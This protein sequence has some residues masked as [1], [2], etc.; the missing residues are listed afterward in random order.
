MN[1]GSTSITNSN[2]TYIPSMDF[3]YFS[4]GKS[5]KQSFGNKISGSIFFLSGSYGQYFYMKKYSRYMIINDQRTLPANGYLYSTHWLQE[6]GKDNLYDVN[7]E[8][9]G[10]ISLSTPNLPVA[11]ATYDLYH[12]RSQ[13]LMESYRAYRNDV[14]A[15]HGGAT[16][17]ASMQFG[18]SKGWMMDLLFPINPH[19]KTKGFSMSVGVKGNGVWEE[20]ND[21]ANHMLF[22]EDNALQEPTQEQF[23]FKNT[24]EKTIYNEAY[25]DQYGGDDPAHVELARVYGVPHPFLPTIGNYVKAKAQ[26]SVK[27]ANS[28]YSQL[29]IPNNANVSTSK[30]KRERRNHFFKERRSQEPLIN[31]FDP[32]LVDYKLYS[33][34][35]G[36]MTVDNAYNRNSKPANHISEITVAN[37][38]G[39]KYIYGIP[40]YNN[41]T[42]QVSKNAGT[43]TVPNSNG[44]VGV[45]GVPGGYDSFERN[46]ELPGYATDYL[47]TASISTDYIDK[48]GD[49]LSEDDHGSYHK[50]N[51]SKLHDNYQWRAPYE[52][53][54]GNFNEAHKAYN[55]DNT[56]SYAYGNKEIWY[57]HSI[58]SKNYIAE[59]YLSDREDAY[60]VSSESGGIGANSKKLKKLDKIELYTKEERITKG[61]TAVPIKTVHFE[62]DYTLC[63]GIPSN[64]ATSGPNDGKLT[65]RKVYFTYGDSD[66]GKESVYD[67]T[68]ADHNHNGIENEAADVNYDYSYSAVDRWGSYKTPVAV[69]NAQDSYTKQDNRALAD[70]HAAAWRLSRINT[71][72]GAE[73]EV[74]YEADDY[75]YVQNKRAM[76]MF[77]I[78]GTSSSLVT[79]GTVPSSS[80]LYTGIAGHNFLYFKLQDSG[81]TQT[82]LAENYFE[83]MDYLYYKAL[84]RLVP[85]RPEHEYVSGYARVKNFGLMSNGTHAW[86]ELD[87]TFFN[88]ASVQPVF[89]K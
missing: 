17:S 85:G 68:Y 37:E 3:Q 43:G 84:V 13:G 64:P 39:G 50:F 71:P 65:L 56:V 27:D 66:K 20:D 47:L 9:S 61:R 8:R 57:V 18:T 4:A 53:S 14:G 79:S 62:Y 25:Y 19:V 52:Q 34:T 77:N 23:Y 41:Y 88:G 45:P 21:A 28:N 6:G 87:P 12:V 49:G 63:Q 40:V 10:L 74:Y 30:D 55:D 38:N 58:E 59:F 29:P 70:K 75:A 36:T 44:L 80:T 81:I 42:K 26:L 32:T 31:F 15:Y 7:K 1:N 82:E 24:G 54:Q 78:V 73:M 48:T 11:N 72:Q 86:L 22:Q 35:T 83:G 5:K 89:L 2:T 60:G 76:Q 69:P 51:Y 33:G 16:K 67:F 46:M